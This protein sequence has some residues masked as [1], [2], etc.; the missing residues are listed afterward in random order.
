MGHYWDSIL[1][2]LICTSQFFELEFLLNAAKEN[3]VNR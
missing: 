2:Y 1:I 3:R